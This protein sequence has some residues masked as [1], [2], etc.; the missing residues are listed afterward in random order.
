MRIEPREPAAVAPQ[1]ADRESIAAP[2][3]VPIWEQQRE[4]RRSDRKALRLGVAVAVALHMVLLAANFP[5]LS[6]AEA[7]KPPEQREAYVVHDVRFQ[8]PPP[9]PPPDEPPPPPPEDQPPPKPE[10]VKVPVPDTTP[11]EPEPVIVPEPKPV[12]VPPK[13]ITPVQ[14]PVT[15]PQPL[16]VEVPPAPPAPPPPPVPVATPPPPPPPPPPEPEGPIR[17]GGDVSAPEKVTAPDPQYPEAA[18]TA[19]IE[20]TVVIEAVIDKNGNVDR[21]RVVKGLPMG[22]DQAAADAVKRWK[23]KPGM[24]A[25]KPVDVIYN[26]TVHFKIS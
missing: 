17:V 2:D 13:Q 11:E 9:P 22:L 3:A 5:E 8:P 23:F 25:G 18:R 15:P 24:R 7:P 10:A 6:K 4:Q 1:G 16:R 20:G 12:V 26:L 14:A 21:V 19:R